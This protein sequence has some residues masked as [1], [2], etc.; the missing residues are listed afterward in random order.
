M[1]TNGYANP[2]ALVGTD[3]L[4]AHL[5]DPGVR[6]VEVDE[7][8]SAYATGHIPGAVRWSWH[9]DLRAAVGR[10]FIDQGELTSAVR[11]QQ[12]LVRR[13]CVLAPEVPGLRLG[14]AVERRQEEVGA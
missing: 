3:W 11:R 14:Q 5:D 7:D 8:V 4:Q 1:G 12:Q 6:V 13:L 10:D 9:T 2:D